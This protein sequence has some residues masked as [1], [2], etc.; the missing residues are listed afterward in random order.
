MRLY[1]SHGSNTAVSLFGWAIECLSCAPRL[2]YFVQHRLVR[3]QY[4][5]QCGF[6][7][8]ARRGDALVHF[9]DRHRHLFGQTG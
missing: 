9:L 1:G 2:A 5:P 6:P 8:V 4:T 3:R 7:F